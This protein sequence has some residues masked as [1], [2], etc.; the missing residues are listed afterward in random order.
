[1]T[2]PLHNIRFKSRCCV[3]YFYTV[4]LLLIALQGL[5][6]LPL[7]AQ[8]PSQRKETKRY[9]R[10]NFYFNFYAT[11]ERKFKRSNIESYG[12][13]QSS[14]GGYL[15]ILSNSWYKNDEISIASFHLLAQ[16][17]FTTSRPQI[18][19]LENNQH[20]LYKLS[21]GLTAIYATGNKNIWY[22]SMQ[23]FISQDKYTIENPT[24]RLA[25]LFI[26]NRTVSANFSYRIGLLRTYMFGENIRNN[27]PLV[28]FR[29]GRLD[30]LHLNMYLLRNISVNF[31]VGKKTWLELFA[32]PIGGLYVFSNSDS[33]FATKG[34]IQFGRYELLNG[35]NITYRPTNSVTLFVSTG[36]SY[37]KKVFLK[38]VKSKDDLSFRAP[39]SMFFNTGINIAIGKSKTIQNN[40]EMYDVFSLQNT[41]SGNNLNGAAN[42]NVPNS[43][44]NS[45]DI[46]KIN[47]IKYNDVKDLLSDE[48]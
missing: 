42:T 7:K 46:E 39:L 19:F 9:I 37:G 13:R 18:G 33:L 26:F 2:L 15:P 44:G 6:L 11:P 41:W 10:P 43:A 5:I 4:Y 25:G 12:F 3:K 21:L 38:D 47:R 45:S 35:I 40:T 14:I 32:K 28:G 36:I 34:A 27:L 30:K 48:L 17:N 20:V 16:G 1:M 24:W 8:E 29:V 22:G 23:P 31:P